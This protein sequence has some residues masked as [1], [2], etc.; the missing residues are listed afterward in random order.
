MIQP[1]IGLPPDKTELPDQLRQ[2]ACNAFNLLV[3]AGQIPEDTGYDFV[4]N[5]KGKVMVHMWREKAIGQDSQ[6]YTVFEAYGDA[7]VDPKELIVA[8]G[9]LKQV[10]GGE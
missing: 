6:G 8:A 10:R 1:L 5:A 3:R 9:P 4:K 7:F 2:D